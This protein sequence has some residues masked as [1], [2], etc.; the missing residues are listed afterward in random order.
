MDDFRI[1]IMPRQHNQLDP[2]RVLALSSKQEVH[3]G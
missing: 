2:T 3:N 1:K